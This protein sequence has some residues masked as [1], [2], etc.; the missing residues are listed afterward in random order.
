MNTAF[1]S[2]LL[3]LIVLPP[4]S[5]QTLQDTKP[6]FTLSGT[7]LDAEG[8][9]VPHSVVIPLSEH[10]IPLRRSNLEPVSLDAIESAEKEDFILSSETNGAGVF[11]FNLPPGKYRLVAQS[12]PGHTGI[13][14]ILERHGSHLRMDGLLELEFSNEME[15]SEVHEIRPIGTA[16]LKVT[17]QE[18]SDMLLISS[19]PFACDIALGFVALMGDFWNGLLAG[20]AMEK[21]EILISGLPAG[22]IQVFSFI[23][24]NNGGIGAGKTKLAEGESGE[25]Y[26][27]VLAGWSNGH[28]TP[29]A[30]L[31]ELTKYLLENQQDLARTDRVM[32]ELQEAF[33]SSNHGNGLERMT[34]YSK[35]L[36]PRLPEEFRLS[37]GEKTTLGEILA[38]AVY[39]RMRERDR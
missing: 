23:N 28:R 3:C 13:Q 30:E 26:V 19:E 21:K 37:N 25:L 33:A 8:Q 38:A 10:G 7:V 35:L 27:G 12:W 14:R 16:S 4:V 36:L 2:L 31:K 29:P 20:T 15:A 22:E 6:I 32:Q 11:S 24:D 9:P 39:A 34:E 5:G 17:S 18:K 1:P